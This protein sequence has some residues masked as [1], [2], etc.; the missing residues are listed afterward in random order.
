VI[1]SNVIQYRGFRGNQYGKHQMSPRILASF[2]T[3]LRTE[4]NLFLLNECENT[5][6][7][8]TVFCTFPMH[9]C[10]SRYIVKRLI[11]GNFLNFGDAWINPRSTGNSMSVL[12]TACKTSFLATLHKLLHV[13]CP[14]YRTFA[15]L[16]GLIPLVDKIVNRHRTHT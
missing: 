2:A 12:F 6:P 14:L 1:T 13:T 4:C 9:K 7:M 8:Q 16:F 5:T 11:F 3:V 15:Q 10:Y